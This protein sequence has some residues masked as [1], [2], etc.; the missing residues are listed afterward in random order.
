[1]GQR[2]GDLLVRRGWHVCGVGQFGGIGLDDVHLAIAGE[3]A[4][5]RIDND[6]RARR[7]AGGDHRRGHDPLAVV[8]QQDEAHIGGH[9][10]D[11]AHQPLL[12]LTLGGSGDFV[13]H[14]QQ[15]LAAGDEAS[16]QCR[17]PGGVS[18]D[19]TFDPGLGGDQPEGFMAL[20]IAAHQAD[21]THMTAQRRD[22][23]RHIAR[24]PEHDQF[25]VPGQHRD[26]RLRRDPRHLA[27]DEAVDHQ[28]ADAGDADTGDGGEQMLQS[29]QIHGRVP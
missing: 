21:Q 3:A 15:L 2:R 9:I 23:A 14:P 18:D 16:L 10:A 19:K 24:R 17:R 6:A 28:V 29:G 7:P 27:I 11:G 1:M 12:D 22:I 20:A 5:L 26:R 13:V 25:T 8:R 4:G